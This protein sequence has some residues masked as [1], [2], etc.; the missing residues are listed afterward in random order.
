MRSLALLA[1]A[2]AH[3]CD[4]EHGTACP[5]AA[6]KAVGDCLKDPSKHEEKVELSAECASFVAL[7]DACAEEI[8][9]AC[10]GNAYNDDTMLC[11]T[12]WTSP[13]QLSDA[14]KAALPKKAEEKDEEVDAEK[15]AWRAQRKAAR[16][17]AANQ[18]KKEQKK[19][20]KAKKGK[21]GKKDDGKKK[22]VKKT[23]DW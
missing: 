13:A 18:M 4:P 9:S 20:E 19:E 8:D 6:G 7:H 17:A 14:C 5:F 1:L 21:K 11:L 16:E 3:P 15:A 12:Q 2:A 22:K 23:D 10:S